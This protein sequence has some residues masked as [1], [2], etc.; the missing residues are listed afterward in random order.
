MIFL[1]INLTFD[2]YFDLI[3]IDTISFKITEKQVIIPEVN[4]WNGFYIPLWD[5]AIWKD[6]QKDEFISKKTIGNGTI[7][8]VF[9]NLCYFI[10]HDGMITIYNLEKMTIV[11]KVILR[12]KPFILYNYDFD[13]KGNIYVACYNTNFRSG[14]PG[15]LIWK[16][17]PDGSLN[18]TFFH[19]PDLDYISYA[20]ALPKRIILHII[21]DTLYLIEPHT[22][23]FFK[24]TLEG[25]L[26]QK[27]RLNIKR[28]IKPDGIFVGNCKLS[29]EELLNRLIEWIKKWTPPLNSVK[30]YE[31]YILIFFYNKNAY[32]TDDSG[33][34]VMLDRNGEV[35][36]EIDADK[37]PIAT[38]D[39]ENILFASSKYRTET[40][41]VK[42][43]KFKLKNL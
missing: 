11:N 39:Q 8:K 25:N 18:N 29:N 16:F 24:Y 21:G 14:Y 2:D 4:V 28:F 32:F 15:Y 36:F 13:S 34:I 3:S 42:I 23:N 7:A 5:N 35:I 38:D 31:N 20:T 40:G 19:H 10:S 37:Q 17:K 12:K 22:L 9:K 6:G 30:I 43:F 26:I 33:F 27:K 41:Y 1:I